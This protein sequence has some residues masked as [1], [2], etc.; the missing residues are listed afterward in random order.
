MLF[1]WNNH[2]E[3]KNWKQFFNQKVA[4]KLIEF[5]QRKL[6]PYAPWALICW[7]YEKKFLAMSQNLGKKNFVQNICAECFALDSR[8]AKKTTKKAV[9]IA[10]F[11]ASVGDSLLKSIAP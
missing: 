7:R 1:G 4:Q 9:H 2:E 6:S 8:R 11:T 10:N 5:Q 3:E